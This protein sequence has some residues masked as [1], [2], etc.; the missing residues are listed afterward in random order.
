MTAVHKSK[1]IREPHW[2]DLLHEFQ[3]YST[4]PAHN[5]DW[6]G[7]GQEQ[8][9]PCTNIYPNISKLVETIQKRKKNRKRRLNQAFPEKELVASDLSVLFY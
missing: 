6:P 2:S 3:T 4:P 9:D 7:A 8:S 5:I 1:C